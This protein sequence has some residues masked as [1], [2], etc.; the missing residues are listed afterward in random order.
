MTWH[1]WY[2]GLAKP[3]WTPAPATISLIWGLL[4]PGILVS[5]GYVFVQCA[6]GRLP[7]G[8][9]VPFALNLLANLAFMPLFAGLRDVHWATADLLVVWATLIWCAVA[10]WPHSRWV[11]VVQVPYF[12]WVSV[13]GVLQMSIAWLNW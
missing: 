13:A 7:R 5:F 3:T 2:D 8:V 9:W 4:Y 11:A 6:R 10:I 1:D 12:A